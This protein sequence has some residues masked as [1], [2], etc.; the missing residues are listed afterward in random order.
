MSDNVNLVRRA[1]EAALASDLDTVAGLLADEVRWHPA[2]D[3]AGGCQNRTQAL[4]W[5]RAAIERGAVARLLELRELDEQRVLVVLERAGAPEPHAQVV[6]VDA[7]KIAE[8]VVYPTAS[9][10]EA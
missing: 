10:A 7:G 2:G 6:T 5:M 1:W 8:I 9:L 3:A 4:R